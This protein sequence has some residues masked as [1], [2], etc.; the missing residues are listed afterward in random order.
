[1]QHPLDG[2]DLVEF[3]IRAVD[4]DRPVPAPVGVAGRLLDIKV[5]DPSSHACIS[6]LMNCEVAGDHQ[7]GRWPCRI[8]TSIRV[9]SSWT[10]FR[11][12]SVPL[13][14]GTGSASTH[15]PGMPSGERKRYL[16]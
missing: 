10:P 11:Y 7:R 4:P 8:S 12:S 9:S 5:H 1:M 14:C 16:H 15:S 3:D 6:T 2:L 13:A